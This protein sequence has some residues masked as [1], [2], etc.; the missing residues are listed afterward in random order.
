MASFFSFAS[1]V[2]VEVRLDS[3]EERQE[4][5]VKLDKDRK[6]AC[7]VYFDGESVRGQVSRLNS[8]VVSGD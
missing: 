8:A 5:E 3:G 1:P 4:V 6:E 7:P 2:E